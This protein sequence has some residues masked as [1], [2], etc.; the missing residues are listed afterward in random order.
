MCFC[1]ALARKRHSIF[2]KLTSESE[3]VLTE[4]E[5]TNKEIA[6]G[7]QYSSGLGRVIYLHTL[8]SGTVNEN[9]T[10]ESV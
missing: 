2:G 7:V 5:E 9:R 1:E 8:Y 10:S 4:L 6:S 3:D